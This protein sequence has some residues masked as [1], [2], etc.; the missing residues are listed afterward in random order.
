MPKPRPT[1]DRRSSPI[2]APAKLAS[3]AAVLPV[4]LGVLTLAGCRK[5]D[6]AK[7]QPQVVTATA[8]AMPAL[9][10]SQPS[11][12]S[13]LSDAPAGIDWLPGDHV[14]AAFAQ[15]RAA[16]RPVLLYWGAVWCPYCKDLKA[17]V[18]S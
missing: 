6:G 18:F 13:A 5:H 10:T 7:P 12:T 2:R 4:L 15:A 14:E 1:S 9:A 11:G 3:V 8:P 16:Q 17:S